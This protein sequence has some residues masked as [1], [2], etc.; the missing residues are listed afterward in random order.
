[1]NSNSNSRSSALFGFLDARWKLRPRPKRRN[2]DS[3]ETL[4]PRALDKNPQHIGGDRMSS[5]TSYASAL[6]RSR[7]GD[8]EAAQSLAHAHKGAVLFTMCLGVFVAQLDSSVVNLAVKHSGG[9]L[10]AGVNQLQWVL[11]SY[12]LV[13]ATLL[14]TGGTL[15]DLYGRTRV[16][17]IGIAL[18]A[19]GS[20]VCA[21]APNPAVLIAGRAVTGLGAALELPTT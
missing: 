18:I 2:D 10:N 13:Y 11:D 8:K 15:G 1:M 20:L 4:P 9:D 6:F 21:L 16:F 12:N 14:L 3:C 7:Q 17:V 5:M 19:A